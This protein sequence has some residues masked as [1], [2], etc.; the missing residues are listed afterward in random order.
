MYLPDF[1]YYS[2]DTLEEACNLLHRFGPDA[3]VLSGGT[4]VLTRMKNKLMA[5]KVLVSLKNIQHLSGIEYIPGK[6]MVI[7]SKVTPNDLVYSAV[8]KNKYPSVSDAAR[9]MANNQVR[10]GEPSAQYCQCAALCRLA[11]YPDDP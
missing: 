7:G 8:L 4:D 10:N 2:P 5:P 9:V 3:K 1:D 11:A 6:G